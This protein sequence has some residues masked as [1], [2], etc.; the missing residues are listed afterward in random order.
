MTHLGLDDW[1][2]VAGQDEE[3][4]SNGLATL[5][6]WEAR[7]DP[8]GIRLP[9]AKCHDDKTITAISFN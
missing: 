3:E 1:A 8:S 4:L 9:R 5:G 6:R 2:A 7:A